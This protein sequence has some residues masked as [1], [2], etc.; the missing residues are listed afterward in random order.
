MSTTR[1]PIRHRA[2]IAFWALAGVALLISHDAIW[3]TQIG[4]GDDLTTALRRGDHGYW[5]AASVG[6]LIAALAVAGVV[7]LRLLRLRRRALSIGTRRGPPAAGGGF[8][9]RAAVAWARLLAV[10]S[11]G[12]L[13]QENVEH[14][15]SHQH[16][17]GVGALFGPE[18]PLAL[19]VIAFITG[20]AGVLAAAVRGWERR[21][22]AAI[23]AAHRMRLRP[24]RQTLRAPRRSARLAFSPLAAA[25]AGRAPPLLLE[26]HPSS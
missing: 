18:Y 21:L 9:W 25:A 10:V 7:A 3:L 14:H 11:I 6:I 22:V 5:A 20:V 13:I 24:I 12:F 15:L 8:A 2:G 1:W 23:L 17:P 19:P 4:P 16:I 26:S